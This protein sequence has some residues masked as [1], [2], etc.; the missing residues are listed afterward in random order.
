MSRPSDGARFA[1]IIVIVVL[2]IVGGL[3]GLYFVYRDQLEAR[4]QVRAANQLY[5]DTKFIE[6]AATYERALPHVDDPTVHFNLGLAY[7]KVFKPG[8]DTPIRLGV[9]GDWVCSTIPDVKTLE[10][11]V[12]AD[13]EDRRYADCTENDAKD[14]CGKR[15]CVKQTL[16]ALDGPTIANMA[17]DHLQKWVDVQASDQEVHSEL[18]Q[19]YVELAKLE[20]DRDARIAD[21]DKT[22]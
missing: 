11:Q 8:V 17:A 2:C 12:C 15:A 19:A 4:E 9:V 18:K 6:A 16:C 5:T 7:A 3:A 10:A 14:V 21:G 22:A 13:D 1:T 20:S